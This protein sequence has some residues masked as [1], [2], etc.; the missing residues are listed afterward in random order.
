MVGRP[1]RYCSLGGPAPAPSS[2]GEP[3]S[4]P[5]SGRSPRGGEQGCATHGRVPG[6][7]VVAPHPE[8]PTLPRL[9]VRVSEPPPWVE[10][11]GACMRPHALTC[12]EIEKLNP[13]VIKIGHF[14]RKEPLIL[15]CASVTS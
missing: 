15:R 11:S 1:W 5:R 14:K 10:R 6:G 12:A 13:W 3:Q 9:S 8:A 7:E 2:E 4:A